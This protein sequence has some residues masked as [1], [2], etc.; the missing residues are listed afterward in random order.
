M[1]ESAVGVRVVALD[2]EGVGGRVPGLGIGA[3]VGVGMERG[4]ECRD[5]DDEGI[6]VVVGIGVCD[7]LGSGS[8]ASECY[9]I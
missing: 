6:D 5:W 2:V 8:C 7:R 4:T 3:R 9:L 1:I